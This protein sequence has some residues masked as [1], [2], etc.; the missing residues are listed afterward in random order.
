V[1]KI[2]FMVPEPVIWHAFESL[3]HAGLVMRQGRVSGPVK[4]WVGGPV[5]HLDLKPENVFIGDYPNQTAQ[6]PQNF[7][8]YPTF[9]LSDFGHSID[10]RR[11][12]QAYNGIGGYRRRGTEDYKAPEQV[13]D[14]Y[15]RGPHPIDPLNT[16]TNEWGVGLIVMTLMN[17]DQETGMLPDKDAR[18]L[19]ERDPNVVPTFTPEAV[20]K[21]SVTLR[22]LVND[23]LRFRQANRP[24]FDVLLNRLRDATG[25]PSQGA[26]QHDHAQ[27]ARSATLTN[28][29]A[30]PMPLL[31][32]RRNNEYTIGFTFMPPP[33]MQAI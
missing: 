27:G 30:N 16:K 28:L 1:N 31:H 12:P 4:R 32:L 26:Q 17:L 3:I 9:K 8:M 7:A 24:D 22:D 14:Q 15:Y 23:C 13:E 2:D 21:Y 33:G 11:D 25:W 20:I 6:N 10:D 29:P 19:N 18:V 5:V